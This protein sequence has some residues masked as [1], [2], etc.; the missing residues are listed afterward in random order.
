MSEKKKEYGFQIKTVELLDSSLK[1]SDKALDKSPV[2][3]FDINIEHRINIESKITIVVCTVS[4]YTKSKQDI[5]GNIKT[6]CIYSI[7]DMDSY[8]DQKSKQ[9]KLPDELAMMLNTVS[10]STTR[11]MMFSFFRGTILH[12]AILPL[13]NPQQFSIPKKITSENDESNS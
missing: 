10:I 13:V 6:G 9:I 3:S 2:Y 8:I 4:I 1:T 12:N 11:G 5:I 7:P